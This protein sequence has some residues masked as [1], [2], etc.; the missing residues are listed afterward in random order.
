MNPLT[1]ARVLSTLTLVSHSSSY[2]CCGQYRAVADIKN[3]RG[4]LGIV[5]DHGRQ[6]EIFV[7]TELICMVIGDIKQRIKKRGKE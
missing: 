3:L 1:V 2:K 6:I 5:K 7:I 4:L